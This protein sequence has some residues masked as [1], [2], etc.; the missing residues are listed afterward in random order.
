[1]AGG[2]GQNPKYGLARS[3]LRIR[4]VI[5]YYASFN[6]SSIRLPRPLTYSQ[7]IHNSYVKEKRAYT[8]SAMAISGAVGAGHLEINRTDNPP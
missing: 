6:K 1:M 2:G 4:K 8:V 7:P 3:V 5:V